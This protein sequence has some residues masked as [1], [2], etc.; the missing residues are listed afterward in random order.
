VTDTWQE[1]A[2]ALVDELRAKGVLRTD[3][4]VRPLRTVPRHRFV[5]CFYE[6]ARGGIWEQVDEHQKERWLST[7]YSNTALV[8]ALDD[9]K[10]AISS[11]SQPSLMARMLEALDVRPGSR[12]LEIGTGT[13]YNVALLATRLG[14]AAVCSVDVDAEFVAQ[15]RE[16]LAAIGLEPTLR[17]TDGEE[18]LPEFAPYDRIIATC[19]VPTVPWAWAEQLSPDG[20]VLVDIK[21]GGAGG[22]LVLLRRTEDGLEG[23]FLAG[24]AGFMPMRH[25]GRTDPA[26][27]AVSDGPVAETVTELPAEPWTN[28]VPWFFTQVSCPMSYGYVLDL[29]TS[30]PTHARLTAPDGSWCV[31]SLD[32][33][34]VRQ[35]GPLRLWDAVDTAHKRWDELSRPE[36]DRLGLTVQRD[37][38]WIW[39]DDPTNLIAGLD[40]EDERAASTVRR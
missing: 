38:Q 14:G 37:Q 9:G 23:R 3:D 34:T 2:A 1:R 40:V 11:S 31:V 4:W 28:R 12:V 35:S 25:K 20:L 6:Q 30:A 8:T 24:W 21:R 32:T 39:I 7:V 33:R 26:R 17:V 19:S 22:N 15:A 16:R 13:G 27:R 36:W 10:V 18:G 5:P 29:A